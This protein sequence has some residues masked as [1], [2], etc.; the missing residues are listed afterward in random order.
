MFKT[1]SE[2]SQ[3]RERNRTVNSTRNTGGLDPSAFTKTEREEMRRA[4][5]TEKSQVQH[6]ISKLN[7][8]LSEAKARRS[9][10]NCGPPVRPELER[11]WTADRAALVQRIDTIERQLVELKVA[12]LNKAKEEDKGF[13]RAFVEA[14][15]DMLAA[16]VLERLITAAVQ[17]M[18]L[19]DE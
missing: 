11:K 8:M 2:N 19:L 14:A 1:T 17:R 18:R 7:A 13:D 12:G 3:R 16:P 4:L 15:K 5:A 9:L 6:S 10:W